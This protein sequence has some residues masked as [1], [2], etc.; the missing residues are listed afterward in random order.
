MPAAVLGTGIQSHSVR[1]FP[2]LPDPC[3][4]QQE[5]PWA[6]VRMAIA[7][8]ACNAVWDLRAK[9]NSLCLMKVVRGFQSG[10][11]E[12]GLSTKPELYSKGACRTV[13]PGTGVCE[14][15]VPRVWG[16]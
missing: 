16:T 7:R 14:V 11:F 3:L 1:L 12:H 4:G 6:P 10:A 9:G 5:A 2:G 8:G 15:R 13:L